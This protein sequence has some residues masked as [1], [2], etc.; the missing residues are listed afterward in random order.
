[1]TLPLVRVEAIDGWVGRF[2]VTNDQFRRF[3]AEHASGPGADAPRQPAVNVSHADAT[4][5]ARWVTQIGRGLPAGTVARLPRSAEWLAIA[6]CGDERAY[7]WGDAWPPTLG[8]YDD[9]SR[10]GGSP[11]APYRDGWGAA[12]A[13][14]ASGRNEWGLYGVGG[15]VWEWTDEPDAAAAG[16]AVRRGG[17]WRWEL[18]GTGAGYARDLRCDHRSY[19][20]PD[21]RTATTGFRIVIAKP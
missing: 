19:A 10:E 11:V 16:W 7:P 20:F 12:C 15:N 18:W 14:E 5:F 8:N 13:V 21:L 4:A 1:M 2:E 9:R 17:G 3:R 6:R